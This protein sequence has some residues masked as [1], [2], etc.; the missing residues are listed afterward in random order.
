M[1]EK[2]LGGRSPIGEPYEYV[3]DS[4]GGFTGK[5]QEYSPDPLV[6]YRW[7][8]IS[9][10]D[11]L[12][13]F[14]KRPVA[15]VSDTPESFSGLEAVNEAPTD[16]CVSSPGT[17]ML[18]FGVECAG[19]LEIDSADLSGTITLGVSEYNQPAFVNRNNETK[20]PSKTAVPI[21][22]GDTYRL[23]LNDELYEGVR[24][25]FINI[26]D[27]AAPFH[28]TDIRLVCQ[29]KPVNYEG[30]FDSDN[31]MLNRIW[32]TAAYDVRANLKQ[33][34]FAAILMDRGDRFSWTG[35]AYPSQAAALSA[36]GNYD[37]V[38]HNLHYTSRR[39]NGIQ[40][41]EM[42]WILSLVDYYQHTGD[43][44]GVQGLINEATLR[45]DNAYKI[46]G[47][48]P[49]LEFFGWDERLGAG[50]ENANTADNQNAFKLICIRAWNEFA[51]VLEDIG[52]TGLAQKYIGYA[53]EKTAELYNENGW[54]ESYG[55]HTAADAINA[56]IVPNEDID[57]LYHKHFDNR[58][59]RLSYSPFNQ[60][61]I[62]QAMAEYGDYDDAIS[63]ILD[64][65][66]GQIEYGGT[67]FFEVYR[68]QW[69]DV[70]GQN[71]PIPN[72]QVGYTSLAHPWSAGVLS[73]MS[74][75]LLG[76]KAES[77]GFET[78]SVT[79][80][81]GRQLTRVSGEMPTPHGT[82]AAS[83]D[84]QSGECSLTVPSG[85]V[86]RIG[87]PK[88]ERT[89]TDIRM[90][91][92][93]VQPAAED[94]DF[95]YF[96]GL[97]QGEYSFIVTYQG[98][99]PSYVQ[100]EYL[101]EAEIIGEDRATAGN[102]NSRYGSDGYLLCNYNKT[103]DIRVLP[104]YISNVSFNKAKSVV[105]AEETKD[106]RA[107]EI[108]TAGGSLRRMTGYTS[109]DDANCGQ[110]FTVDITLAQQKH[111]YT[112]SF[113]FADWE[114]G[115][116]KLAVEMFDGDTYNLVAP[117]KELDDYSGGVY[118]TYRYDNS[119]R[120]RIHQIRG[121]NAA[122]SG[123]FFGEGAA[124]IETSGSMQI[125]DRSA[126]IT[127]SG[128]WD[129]N[130]TDGSYLG[131]HSFVN[132]AAATATYEFEGN[133][134]AYFGSRERNRGIVEILLD[135]V[136]QGEFDLYY[137]GMKRQQRIFAASDLEPGKHT[138]QVVA[139]GK[140]NLKASDCYVD[141]D[142]FEVAKDTPTAITGLFDDRSQ[143]ISYDSGWDHNFAGGTY[144]GTHSFSNLSGT[145]AT[146]EFEGSG[147]SYIGSRESNRG[148]V[149]ILLDGVSQ[150]EFDLYDS[151]VKRQQRIFTADGLG[152]GKHTI[153]IIVTGL[154]NPA[155][156]ASYADID[157]FEVRRAF[158]PSDVDVDW[159][160]V[161]EVIQL[162]EAVSPVD[163]TAGC[164][165]RIRAAESA[166]GILN[167]V[168]QDE[169]TNFDALNEMFDLYSRAYAASHD[170]LLANFDFKN[171]CTDD[172][173]G[174]VSAS[175]DASVTFSD[176][177]ANGRAA[178]FDTASRKQGIKW[179]SEAYHPARL[180]EDGISFSAWVY[181]E[182]PPGLHSTVFMMKS[183]NGDNT[184]YLIIKA[185]PDQWAVCMTPSGGV[186]TSVSSGSP[187]ESGKWTHIVYTQER[188]K[189]C[190]YID[191]ELSGTGFMPE[192]SLVAP[193]SYSMNYALGCQLVWDDPSLPG[194]M[195]EFSIY[196]RALSAGEVA[197]LFSGKADYSGV[198]A[199]IAAA[200]TL[201]ESVYS[202]SSWDKLQK[203]IAA[204]VYGLSD[205]KTVNAYAE[206]I[207][208]AISGLV[209][210]ETEMSISISEGMVTESDQPGKF[211]ITWN[212]AVLAGEAT[213]YEG[214]NESGVKFKKYGVL[215]AESG[216]TLHDY[217][218]A[219][220]DL[221]RDIIFAQGEDIVVYSHFGFRLKNI[222][223]TRTR[224]AM[225]YLEYEFEGG[226]FLIL[227]TIDTTAAV[228]LD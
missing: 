191:G 217:M 123:I 33:D 103:G 143:V 223:E 66:G 53:A 65:W 72:G 225:F 105:W 48:N 55:L 13:I 187:P 164:L 137:D 29:T 178:C 149:E 121:Q 67:T 1:N 31:E 85:T 167:S 17:I 166:Y 119:A 146:F 96:N 23:E 82:I 135:G 179:N 228:L 102:W 154:K 197:V 226:T 50:F 127:Y 198:D 163:D 168:E 39:G 79:P 57:E 177:R 183:E 205:Q 71:A 112:V 189:G 43:R 157:Y 199:A 87:I 141:V 196:D 10:D 160:A 214:I 219:D 109:L 27:F 170:G 184:G 51:G 12:E 138:I 62:L 186:E 185:H 215:Y 22:Y 182:S 6:Q 152:S 30:S 47:S 93:A 136:S 201:D 81:L 124:C 116:R 221:I 5:A 89:I 114:R 104:E 171:D 161:D 16:I 128:I 117:V 99:T 181:L 18:D 210:K 36:F 156:S 49:N 140:K 174:R 69:N 133:G 97:T 192:F 60:Y 64:L 61:F 148:I 32:Y 63:S 84:T 172:T 8:D 194:K 11:E 54:Y 78:F 4:A 208:K 35:D 28:I 220:P 73:F 21:K 173:G 202:E 134:I 111:E 77:P 132:T 9:A 211:N 86:G 188:R 207:N 203:A 209:T 222:T 95:L 94:D 204:V 147:I 162:I 75:E 107:L 131:T 158:E 74:E 41:Y 190:L 56:G 125:D 91:G 180:A 115:G 40:S 68:P 44:A 142:F 151:G 206:T 118:V 3:A 98:E 213:S 76:V 59:N 38:L 216:E 100:P 227:S 176:G 34:Y 7:D 110:S 58:V 46:Y 37:F 193:D 159:Q 165:A 200:G 145:T 45:L 101:Y 42:Y 25:G 122:L 212:A 70:I 169:V 90:N 113:Y 83:F 130:N 24:Y 26:D 20:S 218:N 195:D 106:K 224:A 52:E 155:A 139:T 144:L 2:L 120:F 108:E 150:G 80:H 126:E 14:I 153:Q 88:T 129:H 19:W 15:A 92:Q 175:K